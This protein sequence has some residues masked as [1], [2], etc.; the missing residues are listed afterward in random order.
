MVAAGA[1]AG[2]ALAAC[3]GETP[4]PSTTTT[5]SS[6]ASAPPTVANDGVLRLGVLRPGGASTADLSAS[7]TAGVQ[8]A[9]DEIRSA[10]GAITV[11]VLD[12]SEGDAPVT[13]ASLRSLISSRVDA[14]IG[15]MSS[16]VALASLDV[17]VSS[18]IVTC[19]PTASALALDD[20]PDRGLFFRTVASDSLQAKAIA[21][22]TNQTGASVAG[23]LNLDDGYGRPFADAVET[24]IRAL[25]VSV[26]R[27]PFLDDDTSIKDAA[28]R[29]AA[30]RPPVVA[31]ISDEST[32]D[33]AIEATVKAFGGSRTIVV[34]NDATRHALADLPATIVDTTTVVGVA[35]HAAPDPRFARLI[36]DRLNG[37]SGDFAENAYDCVNLIALAA[38]EARSS[39]P[40]DIAA[41]MVSVSSAGS[42]CFDYPTCVQLLDQRRNIDYGALSLGPNGDVDQAV[43]DTFDVVRGQEVD[44]RTV[45]VGR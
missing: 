21:Q 11:Q 31:L 23:V 43:F 9:V 12:A 30:D 34:G 26:R 40:A 22:V 1:A 37:A 32:A 39:Q 24:D 14:I 5:T 33:A 18:G 35:P 17:P 25:N 2:L 7:I 28:G 16:N 19:S 45:S 20:Y 41:H 36:A 8:Q 13:R 38:T 29:V 15:P 44:A 10:G 27:A 6:V 3:S 4:A 42:S